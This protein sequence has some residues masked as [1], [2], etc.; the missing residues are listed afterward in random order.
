MLARLPEPASQ[1][2]YGRYSESQRYVPHRRGV[3]AADA[4]IPAPV[5]GRSDLR[6]V[7]YMPSS[8]FE[9]YVPYHT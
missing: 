8:L 4:H 9:A 2:S 7:R 3:I 6:I 1:V 5:A